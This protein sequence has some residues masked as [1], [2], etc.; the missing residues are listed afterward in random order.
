MRLVCI[1][2]THKYYTNLDMP[3][4]DVL[5]H[6][7][8]IDVY[9]NIT[10]V[11]HFKKWLDKQKYRYKLVIAGNHDRMFELANDLC[12]SILSDS[13]TY[14]ENSQTTIKGIKFWGSPI[15]PTFMNWY[16]MANRGD[17]ITRYWDMIPK[18]TD[19]LITHGPPMKILD[20]TADG[21]YAGCYDLARIIK[22]IKPK[23]H[24]FG[25]IH[26][27]A[28]QVKIGDTTYINASVLDENYDLVNKPIVIDI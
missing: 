9:E 11:Y 4:G 28:G 10:E 6:A 23:V 22:Q 1:S 17:D 27:G 12:R 3:E 15:T 24:V 14:L 16:F 7:G 20:K 18:D 5:I 19:V 25:H 8:D 26:E 13:C 2:D 21:D